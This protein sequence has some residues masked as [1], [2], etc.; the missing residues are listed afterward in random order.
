MCVLASLTVTECSR[1]C[2][3]INAPAGAERPAGSTRHD[4]DEHDE[5]KQRNEHGKRGTT[6]QARGA[7]EHAFKF[8]RHA[9]PAV[10]QVALAGAT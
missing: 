7:A 8:S 9:A 6:Q 3:S 1:V 2:L 5:L 4:G 10:H